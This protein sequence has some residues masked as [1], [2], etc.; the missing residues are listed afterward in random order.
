MRISTAEL[1]RNFGMYGDHALNEPVIVTRNGRDRLAIIS[2]DEYQIYQSMIRNR[3]LIED[4]LAKQEASFIDEMK[5]IL[6]EE[7]TFLRQHKVR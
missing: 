7:D 6:A 3:R 4:L 2:I 1:L 5:A